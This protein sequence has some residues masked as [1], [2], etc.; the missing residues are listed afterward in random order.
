VT[1]FG[2]EIESTFFGYYDKVPMNRDGYVIAHATQEITACNSDNYEAVNIKIY[3]KDDPKNELHIIS[4][5][6]FNWQQGSRAHWIDDEH[7]IYNVLLEETYGSNIFSIKKGAV[8]RSFNVP[9]QDSYKNNYFLSLNYSR[10]R[11][12]RPEYGYHTL[13]NQDSFDDDSDGI[14][15][16]DMSN[17]KTEL[18]VSISDVKQYGR[19]ASFDSA[20]HKFNHIMISPNG[21]LFICLHRYFFRKVKKDRLILFDLNGNIKKV[22]ADYE[23]VSHCYWLNDNE[24]IAYMRGASGADGYYIININSGSHEPFLS[25]LIDSSGDG[26]PHVNGNRLV[27]DTYPNKS[28]FQELIAVDLETKFN[29]TIGKFFHG[30]EY[31]GQSRCD[32]HP[33]ISLCG[34]FVFF[35]SVFSGIR[36]LYMMKI[37][38]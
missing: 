21:L 11:M 18:I 3:H 38:E 7:I 35:D 13:K 25:G 36:K 22:L 37:D 15:Y 24:V 20:R 1:G 23:M 32:L 12:M 28:R 4:T 33:R 5:N 10:L 6:A 31:N 8:V 16:V 26:H 29:R 9:V 2:C 30:F 19:S 27:T 17:G 14:W 34:K